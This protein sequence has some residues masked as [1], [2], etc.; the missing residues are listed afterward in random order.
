MR[1]RITAVRVQGDE[2]I[3]IFGKEMRQADYD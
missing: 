2:I 1:G 3:Q